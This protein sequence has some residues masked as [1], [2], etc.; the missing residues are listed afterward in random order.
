[1]NVALPAGSSLQ[2]SSDGG[3]TWASATVSGTTWSYVDPVSHP[4]SFSYSVRVIDTAGNTGPL[5]ATQA[6]VIDAAAPNQPTIGL[7]RGDQVTGTAEAGMSVLVTVNGTSAGTVTANSLG[8]WTLDLVPDA[9]H[10]AVI[11]AQA[12][13]AAG[14]L[15][16]QATA[17]V[18][19]SAIIQID[20]TLMGDNLFNST[21]A[22]AVQVTG[23]SS[24]VEAGQ[25]VQVTL[26]DSSGKVFQT[27][28][29]VGIDGSW[30]TAGVDLL[31][32]SYGVI[33]ITA[34][35]S[36]QLG[37]AASANAA[38]LRYVLPVDIIAIDEDLGILANDF[39]TSDNELTVTGTADPTGT[40]TLTGPVRYWG[41][42]GAVDANGEPVFGELT[43][44]LNQVVE[45]APD[46]TWRAE[47]VFGAE[48]EDLAGLPIPLLDTTGGQPPYALTATWNIGTSSFGD[49]AFVSV[50]TAAPDM[51]VQ[52]VGATS[53]R[54]TNTFV[55][56]DQ[57]SSR[58][59]GLSDGGYVIVWTSESQDSTSSTDVGLY[60][61]RYDAS[62]NRINSEFRVNTTLARNQGRLTSG[63]WEAM[64]DVVS[65]PTTG[66]FAVVWTSTQP[67]GSYDVNTPTV[68]GIGGSRNIVGQ[69]YDANGLPITTDIDGS[70]GAYAATNEFIVN[71]AWD[72]TTTNA[73]LPRV[74]NLDNGN[75]AVVWVSNANATT[76]MGYDVRTQLFDAS[77][78]RIG[79]EISVTNERYNQGYLAQADSYST[80]VDIDNLAITA[81]SGGGF[82]VSWSGT[83]PILS[84][85]SLSNANIYSATFNSAGVAV[86][87][88]VQVNT[89][90]TSNQLAPVS[91][92]LNDGSSVVAWVSNQTGTYD[93]YSQR[94]D[95]A[96]VGIGGE[97]RVNV[98]VAGNQ[99][100]LSDI[101]KELA[102]TALSNGGYVVVWAGRGTAS[103]TNDN[104][105]MRVYSAAGTPLSS[106]DTV[107]N[108][109]VKGTQMM[110]AVAA[111]E[112]GGFVVTWSSQY[113]GTDQGTDYAIMQR[114]YNDDGTLRPQALDSAELLVNVGAT[115]NSQYGTSVS[116]SPV[117]GNVAVSWTARSGTGGYG[118]STTETT[119]AALFDRGGRKIADFQ[120]ANIAGDDGS[121]SGAAG[122]GAQMLALSNGNYVLVREA[123]GATVGDVWASIYGP[124]GA[125]VKTDFLAISSNAL[126]QN[127]PAGLVELKDATGA[128]TGQWVML[129]IGR[130]G[131]PMQPQLGIFN[132]DGSDA[133]LTPDIIVSSHG[134]TSATGQGLINTGAWESTAHMASSN[135]RFAVVWSDAV[136]E[137]GDASGDAVYMRIFSNDGTKLGSEIQVNVETTNNQSAPKIAALS[138][139]SFLVT[140]VD[141][142]VSATNYDVYMQRFAADGSRLSSADQLVTGG[143][144][145]GNQGVYGTANAE[146][147]QQHDVIALAGGGWVVSFVDN[148]AGTG[149]RNVLANIYDAAGNLMSFN[150]QLASVFAGTDEYYPSLAPLA[151][152]GFVASWTSTNLV[153][154]DTSGTGTYMRYFDECG[155]VRSLSEYEAGGTPI[156]I[157]PGM[158]VGG[159][160]NADAYNQARKDADPT[161]DIPTD[162]M[163]AN[164]DTPSTLWKAEVNIL[165][166]QQGDVLG[167]DAGAAAAAGIAATYDGAGHLVMVL[168]AATTI[169]DIEAVLRSVTYSG[170]ATPAA[171]DRAIQFAL[172]DK[173]GATTTQESGI[174][175][176]S[177]TLGLTGTPGDDVLTGGNGSDGIVGMG[178]VDTL[179]GG[180]GDD[181]IYVSSTALAGQYDGDQGFD[182]LVLDF[183]GTQSVNLSAL[184]GHAHGIERIDLGN[185]SFVSNSTSLRIDDL[186]N[187]TSIVDAG[188]TRLLVQG[189]ANDSV[190]LATSLNLTKV[191]VTS[192]DHVYFDIYQTAGNDVQLW[193]QQGMAVSQV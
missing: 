145:T 164:G 169:N 151:N 94:Y 162:G 7:T 137:G 192:E 129:Y 36:D 172:I 16:T 124:N 159:S 43:Y 57:V 44:N 186:S 111:L 3:A 135:G 88:R 25:V 9:V 153:L 91:A 75:Y 28:A 165:N 158:L 17:I 69:R 76:G 48:M 83:D 152:G 180:S 21:E 86:G 78:K 97:T 155:N 96:G 156:A 115:T 163:S 59:A 67:G 19:A 53:E 24:D 167:W 66:G 108:Q 68:P 51:F 87:T 136:K 20:G 131:T 39:L 189:S 118:I 46:G 193:L 22:N 142:H 138:D 140:W 41:D 149:T 146:R 114:A 15:S 23:T 32:A 63:D 125:V 89:G 178:G 77:W 79:G 134:A 187:I 143:F 47:L 90:T 55:K 103:T 80:N 31:S 185:T 12:Q 107:I 50:D 85:S 173:A 102:V 110:P 93:V 122:K 170:G 171:G 148:S 29:T 2:V 99:G 37:N 105:Y 100:T 38:T 175:V 45:I 35:V 6:I 154:G 73:L 95:A 141:N 157:E 116:A 182:T 4:T 184:V 130:A 40:L 30:A 174:T 58:V 56:N 11:G 119:Q 132:A 168:G 113:G 10:G 34:S 147:A 42:T 54:Q 13:D 84:T 60:G 109:V 74:I 65:D 104:V 70:G 191:A 166:Y 14:N 82:M 188:V 183:T 120:V 177:S 33:G 121:F 128:S 123:Q 5:V 161:F 81:K 27:T 71:S 190:A 26:T 49:T 150:L 160:T 133:L 52:A 98:T 64:F 72:S 181:R 117:T 1:T 139:G 176:E 101:Q 62:G 126:E 106:Q 179:H 127:G 144:T 112:G 61:Q 18:D 92:T 8:Q